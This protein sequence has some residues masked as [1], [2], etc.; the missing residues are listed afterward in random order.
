MRLSHSKLSLALNN[1]MEY[2]LNYKIG[3]QPKFE[4]KALNLGSAVHW[5]LENNTSNLD[6]YF[7]KDDASQ[8]RA[9]A[10]AM[11]H[12]FLHHKA[13]VFDELLLDENGEQ[14][15]LVEELHE[16]SVTGKLKSFMNTEPHDF[17]GIIDLL[18]LT[19]KGFIVCD[20]KTSSNVPDWDNYLDQLYRYIFLLNSYF[21]EIPVV[22]LAIINL[23][24]TRTR[25]VRG[26]S[27]NSYCN[28]L[29]KEYEFNDDS[30]INWHCF[31]PNT[32]D[33]KFMNDY[34]TNL[35]KMADTAELMDNNNCYY[36]NYSG[37]NSYGGSV[38]KNII[39]QVPDC[40]V[41]YTIKDTILNENNELVDRRDCV[42]IDMQCIFRNDLLNKYDKFEA[43]AISLFS[44]NQNTDKQSLFEFLKKNFICD[45]NLLE[46]YWNTLLYKINIQN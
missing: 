44:V 6:E 14:L 24:K 40:H 13:Q 4:K 45:D 38:Y 20:Y 28:R 32:F 41:L 43:N 21:P 3:I 16:L 42:A 15:E 33:K 27:Y 2:Y 17:V 26:E 37:T 18:L 31:N 12:G 35:S 11:V 29:K 10:E 34:I 36:I 39:Y 9:L 5:G 19:N 46:Q 30:L 25:Q 1:P 23:R 7:G 22:K 8:D